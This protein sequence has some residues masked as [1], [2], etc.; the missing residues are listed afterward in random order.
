MRHDINWLDLVTSDQDASR[1]GHCGPDLCREPGR[2]PTP[3]LQG[4]SRRMRRREKPF[5]ALTR[6]WA[7]MY[8]WN[9]F[10]NTCL[11]DFKCSPSL[12]G[13]N[14][15]FELGWTGLGQGVSGIRVWGQ[16]LTIKYFTWN[17]TWPSK[18]AAFNWSIFMAVF[19]LQA[20]Q[21]FRSF[22]MQITINVRQQTRKMSREIKL[23]TRDQILTKVHVLLLT[24]GPDLHELDLHGH[25]DGEEHLDGV[26]L[27]QDQGILQREARSGVPSGGH[28]MGGQVNTGLWLVNTGHVTWI[29]SSHWSG[30]RW[31]TSTWPPPSAWTSS[32]A[33]R[34]TL[35]APT[36]YILEL[37]SEIYLTKDPL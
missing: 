21:V 13:T 1:R 17:Q 4:K 24:G 10:S 12:L 37:R 3:Q 25:V 23:W 33:A 20:G 22:I 31:L 29:L 9:Q 26:C 5:L 15:V 8:A 32:A 28:E 18:V 27:P 16:G 36:L 7:F 19:F 6:L 30:T 14:W 2:S 35:W 34:N 11:H